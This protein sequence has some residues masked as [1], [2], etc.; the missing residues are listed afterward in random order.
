MGMPFFP[1]Q[2]LLPL[3][4]G[5]GRGEGPY[6]SPASRV[7]HSGRLSPAQ[8]RQ[9]ALMAATTRAAVWR[10]LF[11]NSPP[12]NRAITRAITRSPKSSVKLMYSVCLCARGR[13]DNANA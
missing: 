6:D 7:T 3:P 9:V 11:M 1:G 2:G 12:R 8:T 5:E 4:L 10:L 13:H